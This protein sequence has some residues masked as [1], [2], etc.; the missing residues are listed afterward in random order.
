MSK[1]HLLFFYF[2]QNVSE[3]NTKD[4]F[5]KAIVGL[6]SIF[7]CVCLFRNERFGGTWVVQRVEHLTLDFN[8]GHDFMV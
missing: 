8:S 6:F 4:F 7:D 5:Y 1:N 2:R 3:F